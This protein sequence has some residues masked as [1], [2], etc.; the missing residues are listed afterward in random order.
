MSI[1]PDA[2]QGS[3]FAVNT[4]VPN[5]VPITSN[6]TNP[7]S[8]NVSAIWLPAV[9]VINAS[10]IQTNANV[11]QLRRGWKLF[12][13]DFDIWVNEMG[14]NAAIGQPGSFPIY[15]GDEYT[16]YSFAGDGSDISQA[17]V[18]IISAG[19]AHFTGSYW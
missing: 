15:A 9:G 19:A 7:L 12:A 6:F 10:N 3:G 5:T 16:V 18:S 17:Q 2:W 4:W 13:I 14:G 1:L 8:P 11:A